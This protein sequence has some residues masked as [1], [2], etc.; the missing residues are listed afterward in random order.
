M[1]SIVP[2]IA[3]PTIGSSTSGSIVDTSSNVV[4]RW[5]R[6]RED[7]VIEQSPLRLEQAVRIRG[8]VRHKWSHVETERTG[9]GYIQH[10]ARGQARDVSVHIGVRVDRVEA[11]D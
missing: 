2:S 7:A 5:R 9:F 6:L 3:R 4:P 8:G 11:G 1:N 10:L